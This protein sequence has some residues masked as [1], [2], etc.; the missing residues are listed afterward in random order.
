MSDGLNLMPGTHMMEGENQSFKIAKCAPTRASLSLSLP[1]FLSLSHT[2]THKLLDFFS[3][4]KFYKSFCYLFYNCYT[5]TRTIMISLPHYYLPVLP[6]FSTKYL[7]NSS[8]FLYDIL[9][10]IVNFLCVLGFHSCEETL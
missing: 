8:V 9:F 2:L 5:H 3:C 10:S 1:L 4:T 7:V 6:F